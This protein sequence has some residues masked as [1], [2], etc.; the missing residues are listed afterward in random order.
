MRKGNDIGLKSGE[1]GFTLFELILTSAVGMLL[2]G[3]G[4]PLVQE[5]VRQARADGGM[6]L[7]LCQLR[8]ARQFAVSQRRTQRVTFIP[9][10]TILLERQ[11]LGGSWTEVSRQPLPDPIE[12]KVEPGVPQTMTE[13]PD[14]LGAA[15]AISFGGSTQVYFDAQ[16]FATDAAGN[17]TNGIVYL[18]APGDLATARA[19][20]LVGGT[21]RSKSWSLREVAGE[22][23]WKE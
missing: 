11:E 9:P 14:R 12:F 18:S 7:T 2:L 3:I 8:L 19:V 6:S 17:P 13:T 22:W 5:S 16:S 4:L 20:T 1:S 15:D 23:Q 10:A 21:G